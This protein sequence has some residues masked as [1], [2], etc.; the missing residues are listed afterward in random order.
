MREAGQMQEAGSG[1]DFA[2]CLYYTSVIF[3]LLPGWCDW[4]MSVL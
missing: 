3:V 1:E 4:A 2:D